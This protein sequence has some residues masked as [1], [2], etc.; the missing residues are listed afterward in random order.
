MSTGM[1]SAIRPDI[2]EKGQTCFCVRTEMS[3][4]RV[5]AHFPL[6]PLS[7]GLGIVFLTTC[8]KDLDKVIE[9]NS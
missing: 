8:P 2:N 3:S 9:I 4:I 1:Q 7:S 5:C 6:K